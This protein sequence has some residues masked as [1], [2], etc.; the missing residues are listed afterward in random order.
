MADSTFGGSWWLLP[1]STIITAPNK[2]GLTT[3]RTSLPASSEQHGTIPEHYNNLLKIC[4]LRDPLS[5]M[6][7]AFQ[8]FVLEADRVTPRPQDFAHCEIC[9]PL[10][11]W[12]GRERFCRLFN[13]DTQCLSAEELLE[14][15]I[16]ETLPLCIEHGDDLHFTAQSDF[17]SRM[18]I[19]LYSDTVRVISTAELNN[20]I[21][22]L[23][24]RDPVMTNTRIHD[25]PL[26]WY[27]PWADRVR[28]LYS[29]DHALCEQFGIHSG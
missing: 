8:Q 17:Y 13:R 28:R 15:H 18:G 19:D 23:T 2:T 7:S 22:D 29:E 6:R 21:R 16:T 12:M 27:A 11:A 24:G 14:Q 20:L 10:M 25:R 26:E 5:R 3:C 9:T 4:V 1:N